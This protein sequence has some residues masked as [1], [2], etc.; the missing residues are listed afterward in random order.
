MP[1]TAAWLRIPKDTEIEV[2]PSWTLA[3]DANQQL[4]GTSLILLNR[5]C[6]AVAALTAAEWM[7]LHTELQRLEV[8]IGGLLAPDTYDHA[9][10]GHLD[11][12]VVVHIVPRYRQPREWH[13]ER[14]DD[15]H[16]GE[17]FSPDERALSD[18]ALRALRDALRDRLPRVV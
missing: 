14:F 9:I 13:G 3:I 12:Q 1:S 7:D 16:W 2:R 17:V 8:A 5:P 15:T 11:H 18:E 10:L 4:L 6:E